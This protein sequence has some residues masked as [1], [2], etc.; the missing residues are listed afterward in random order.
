V[1]MRLLCGIVACLALL[2]PSGHA[3]EPHAPNELERLWA[4]LCSDDPLRARQAIT[5]LAARAPQTL[6]FLQKQLM[7]V[8]AAEPHRLAVL[9]GELDSS[10]FQVR[11]SAAQMLEKIGEPAGPSLRKALAA[12]PSSEVSRRIEQILE[13]HKEQRLHPSPSQR[14][15]ERAIEVLEE[16]GNPAARRLLTTL[17]QG[18]PE[19]R[20]TRD[21]KGALNRLRR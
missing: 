8:A 20:L 3:G 6:P 9:I 14:R 15:L 18:A 16:I 19:A 2:G 12:R 11:Q 17:A 4:D 7:P 21:A 13:L 1:I 10:R 5:A